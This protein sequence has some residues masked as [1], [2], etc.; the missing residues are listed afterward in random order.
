MQYIFDVR[1]AANLSLRIP[2]LPAEHQK[3]RG[4]LLGALSHFLCSVPQS[5][6]AVVDVFDQLSARQELSLDVG[7]EVFLQKNPAQL[8][9]AVLH[10]EQF[11]FLTK[12]A[13]NFG[14]CGDSVCHELVSCSLIGIAQLRL[15][16]LWKSD[17]HVYHAAGSVS[18]TELHR[19]CI[20][21][22]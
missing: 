9:K 4:V 2:E 12:C 1:N 5:V 19:C 6:E 14:L 15:D 3:I 20:R 13:T 21:S 10:G 7:G 11:V 22:H 18:E 17:G 8:R 16:V